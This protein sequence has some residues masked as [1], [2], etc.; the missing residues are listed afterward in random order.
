MLRY[1]AHSAA[2]PSS[3]WP[4]LARPAAWPAWAPHL[5][6][7]WGLGSPEVQVGA[8]GA[9]RLL[10]VV[11][12]PAVIVAKQEGRSWTWRVGVVEMDHGVDPHVGGGSTVFVTMRAP[13][14]VEALLRV[15]Y[16]PVVARL[17]AHLAETAA[18][19][20]EGGGVSR[21]AGAPPRPT[22]TGTPAG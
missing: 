21:S 8:R 16:G 11:P 3:V 5:R 19:A 15:S 2:P 6:G 18:R 7:A 22:D 14:P 1:S 12:I 10:G 4:L 17:V 20:A 9:A 13:A